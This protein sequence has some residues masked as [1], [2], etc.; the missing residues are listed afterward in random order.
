MLGRSHEATVFMLTSFIGDFLLLLL[1]LYLLDTGPR[2]SPCILL[3]NPLL[4]TS[5]LRL[6]VLPGRHPGGGGS[7][8]RTTTARVISTR[9]GER[10]TSY[11]HSFIMGYKLAWKAAIAA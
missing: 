4:L 1:P 10:E 11:M 9:A 7:G 8:D 2:T 3:S 6:L 5:L